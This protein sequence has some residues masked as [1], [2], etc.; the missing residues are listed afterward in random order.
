MEIDKELIIGC[1]NNNRLSQ[2]KLYKVLHG[3]MLGIAFKYTNDRDT[4]V[5][6]MNIGF[7]KLITKLHI[8][9]FKTP[10]SA[11]ARV[12]IKN[13]IIDETRREARYKV[14][15]DL[16][17]R[18]MDDSIDNLAIKKLDYEGLDKK[19]DVLG[20]VTKRVVIMQII[21]GFTHKQIAKLLGI[22]ES[23]SKWHLV[24]GKNILRKVW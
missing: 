3:F 9:D 22:S 4:A 19:L 10:F 5:N 21:E 23:L 18:H 1:I 13:A 24:K 20:R 16:F 12:L 8:Y 15:D 7:Y 2:H 6:Y 17:V 14:K 11:W